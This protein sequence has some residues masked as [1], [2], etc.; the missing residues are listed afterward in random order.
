MDQETMGQRC[1]FS[2]IRKLE[3]RE[4]KSVKHLPYLMEALALRMFLSVTMSLDLP[5]TS[6]LPGNSLK[7]CKNDKISFNKKEG[8]VMKG[9]TRAAGLQRTF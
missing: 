2:P 5:Q 1:Y 9:K 6:K 8:A 4:W 7:C 3:C